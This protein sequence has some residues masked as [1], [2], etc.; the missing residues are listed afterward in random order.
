MT[1][2]GEAELLG[3]VDVAGFAG[4]EDGSAV[5]KP[6]EV[7]VN[8]EMSG[9][10]TKFSQRVHGERIEVYK[11]TMGAKS[12]P[13][14]SAVEKQYKE[15]QKPFEQVV[16]KMESPSKNYK[17]PEPDDSD[18]ETPS[19]D[20]GYPKGA[21]MADTPLGQ[22]KNHLD[23]VHGWVKIVACLAVI[24]ILMAAWSLGAVYH[25]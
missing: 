20:Y 15:V 10:P 14:M 19:K 25:P 16:G 17:Q 23:Q 4:I 6:L 22:M 24:G 11:R 3:Y 1:K 7:S 21:S 13:Q 8:R 9:L 12:N 5:I 2:K 18:Y